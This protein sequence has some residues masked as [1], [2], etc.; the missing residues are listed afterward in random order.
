MM[1]IDVSTLQI[2]DEYPDPRATYTYRDALVLNKKG[3]I[4]VSEKGGLFALKHQVLQTIA[5]WVH[6]R[7]QEDVFFICP[8]ATW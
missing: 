5:Q 2:G 7:N 4:C 1:S 8:T 6:Q 3:E